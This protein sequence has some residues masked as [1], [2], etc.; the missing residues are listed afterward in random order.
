MS[1]SNRLT[2]LTQNP[3][4]EFKKKT[5]DSRKRAGKQR[6]D[7]G[8]SKNKVNKT[9]RFRG[10]KQGRRVSFEPRPSAVTCHRGLYLPNESLWSGYRTERVI[11]SYPTTGHS[12]MQETNRPNRR[13]IK[14]D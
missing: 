7:K 4:K 1:K 8:T 11:P 14:C 2:Q 13:P 5:K 10:D 12:S 9:E 6:T 3:T